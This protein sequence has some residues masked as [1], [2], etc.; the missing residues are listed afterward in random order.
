MIQFADDIIIGGGMAFTFVKSMGGLIGRSIF[1]DK[2]EEATKIVE[3][4][5]QKNV[6]LY[7]PGCHMFKI[8]LKR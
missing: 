6:N 7:F 2:I 8:P 4:A 1:E 3:L 5:R